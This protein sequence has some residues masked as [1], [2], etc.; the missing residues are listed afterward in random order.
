LSGGVDPNFSST[1]FDRTGQSGISVLNRQYIKDGPGMR[2]FATDEYGMPL[3]SN[4][5]TWGL[6]IDP[7]LPLFI[8]IA[9]GDDFNDTYTAVGIKFGPIIF[10]LYQS[11]ELDQKIAKDLNW[12]RDRMRISFSLEGMKIPGITL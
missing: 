11:W 1:V 12:V 6:N 4:G 5:F 8:D 2:G 10:P 9:G 7:S 3:S